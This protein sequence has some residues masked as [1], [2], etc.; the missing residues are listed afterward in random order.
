MEDFQCPDS[1]SRIAIS[2]FIGGKL[3]IRISTR[4][5]Y[6]GVPDAG[7]AVTVTS[8]GLITSPT[9]EDMDRLLFIPEGAREVVIL[10]VLDGTVLYS[11]DHGSLTPFDRL[12]V[13][14]GR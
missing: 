2:A 12:T 11:L 14:S 3:N 8:S 7:R 5:D 13:K 10:P 4:D 9:P 1:T 6:V